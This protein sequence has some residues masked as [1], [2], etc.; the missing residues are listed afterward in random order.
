MFYL[1]IVKTIHLLTEITGEILQTT[2]H[3]YLKKYTVKIRH[4]GMK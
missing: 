2:L 3:S 1:R 4:I